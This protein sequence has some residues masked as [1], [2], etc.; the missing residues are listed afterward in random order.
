[1]REKKTHLYFDSEERNTMVGL[2][3][4]NFGMSKYMENEKR[5]SYCCQYFHN[6]RCDIFGSTMLYICICQ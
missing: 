1:M 3:W 6:S 2:N 4:R 5:R